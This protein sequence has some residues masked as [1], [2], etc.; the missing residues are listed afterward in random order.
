MT[1]VISIGSGI[2]APFL[3]VLRESIEAA[4]IV[5]IM[6]AYLDKTD[7]KQY[8]K[9]LAYGT[10]GA[11]VMSLV[12]GGGIVL[13]LGQLAGFWEKMFEGVASISATLVLSYVIIWMAKHAVSI[14]GELES[15]MDFAIT[16]QSANSLVFLAFVAVA[17]E[18]LETVLFLAPLLA[19][20][21]GS[22]ILGS[23]L[24]IAVALILSLAAKRQIYALDI[25]KFFKYTSL[26][27]IVF[28]AGLFGYGLHELVE[29]AEYAGVGYD[30]DG[31]PTNFLFSY[32]WDINPAEKTHPLHEKGAIGVWFKALLGYDGNPEWIR[33]IGYLAYW[34]W[35]GRFYRKTYS[36]Q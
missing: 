19:I 18:G 12:L 11:I 28:A 32:A 4:L 15:K 30:A 22:T 26:I 13:I 5:G 29:A 3:V 16:A 1:E 14:K 25:G 23:V 24:A 21:I 36:S 31:N 8:Q 27:L 7:N 33:V 17:R 9:Y 20:N 35:A 34:G 6:W 10:V 2:I